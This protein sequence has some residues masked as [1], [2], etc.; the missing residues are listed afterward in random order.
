MAEAARFPLAMDGGDDWLMEMA[1]DEDIMI[2]FPQREV[3]PPDLPL[4]ARGGPDRRAIALLQFQRHMAH[5]RVM[6][7]AVV[8][9]RLQQVAAGNACEMRGC[10]ICTEKRYHLALPGQQNKF[11]PTTLKQS[12]LLEWIYRFFD[13][14]MVDQIGSIPLPDLLLADFRQGCDELKVSPRN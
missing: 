8:E 11:T 3:P 10:R 7:Q 13:A 9:E 12:I 14:K 5:R 4:L 2:L 1:Q 6:M